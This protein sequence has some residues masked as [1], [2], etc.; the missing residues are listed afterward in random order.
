[1][2]YAGSE[3]E[4][5][6]MGGS[7][8]K[9]KE[10]A[11]PPQAQ[12]VDYGALMAQ[13]N[14]SAIT[15][16]N[17][18]L[19]AQIKA[20][21]KLEA[22][23]LG[24][25]SKLS[26]ILNNDYTDNA[27]KALEGAAGQTE[28]LIAAGDR[29]GGVAT[30]AN[31]LSQNAEQFAQ[32]PTALDGQIASLGASAMGQRADQVS[33]ARVSDIGRM[34]AAQ[35]GPV[36]DVS[37]PR[38]YSPA[39][40]RAQQINAAQAGAVA[41][42]QAASTGTPE[43]VAGTRVSGVGPMQSARVGRVQDVRSSDIQA[44]AAENALMREA[45]GGGLSGQLQ[46]QAAAELA[47]GRS[48]SAEQQ[49][50]ATQSARSGFAARG[51]ATGN[52]ALAG[53]MLNRDRYATQ[54]Q[55]ERRSFASGALQQSTGIQQAANQAYMGR[56]DSNSGR[57]QQAALSNQSVAQ[58]RAMQNA[59]FAQQAGLTDNQNAQ[60]RV[61]AEAGYAQQAGLSNQDFSF[62][63]GSQDAQMAMQ[64]ALA[65][66]QAGLSLGQ[67]NAQLA[68]QAALA[69]QSA[70]L[71]AGQ[72]NQA[73]NARAQEFQQQGALQAGL[74]NQNTNMQLGL[75]NAQFEQGASAASY[76]AAKSQALSQAG[77]DQQS[78]LANQDANQRQVEMNRAFLQ[79]ANQNDI[80]SQI[81]RGNYAMTQLGQSANLYG[82]QAGAY[83]N[84][85]GI[86]LN[87]AQ[88]NIA[89]D[90]TMRA[91][92]PAFGIG[93]GTLGQSGQMIGNTYNNATQMAGNVA[94]VN[95]SMLDSRWNT[96]QNNNA[97][98]QTAYMGAKASSD[99]ANMGLQGSAIGASAVIGAA[100]AA[101]WVARAAFGTSTSR[102][103]LYR[104]AML[105]SAS[106]RT[107]RL[108]CQYGPAIATRITTPV[109]RFITRCLLRSLEIAWK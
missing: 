11:S 107:I 84:A 54:R 83:Q 109:R 108:Y 29:I 55:N 43:R 85:A 82:Q 51:M 22:L 15:Q 57:A 52:S 98:L 21:P 39:E 73:A 79:N 24:T 69:N 40:I 48:L 59:Q 96:V 5:I 16:Y 65:N 13:A 14:R 20:Y 95:A 92:N 105:R 19:E 32:G 3:S 76:D 56:Q 2:E 94:G 53:E 86:G 70:G 68:Q 75:S 64:A 26:G 1:V 99:A 71:Q 33:A 102:W 30:R 88:A 28:N 90:P 4:A 17:K 42:V 67:S 18:Q 80:N 46:Q 36:A 31:D 61:I 10:Q 101:C 58:S 50:D 7:P 27:N 66:Q 93:Q 41:N 103:M 104:R 72:L 77:Y 12:P 9:P 44:S 87:I 35:A 78:S 37:G 60:Q 91:V 45:S 74:A 23:Q 6:V 38:G 49:R 97:S 89:T 63:A 34:Q 25:I 106:D 62:R 47:Q 81:S 100:A 8:S